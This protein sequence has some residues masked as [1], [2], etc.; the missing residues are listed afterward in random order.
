[1]LKRLCDIVA[2]TVGLCLLVPVFI[3]IAGVVKCSDGGPVFFRQRRI[4][5]N[6]QPFAIWKFR[7]M[8]VQAERQGGQITV[9]VD[10]RVTPVGHWLRKSKL[11]EFPQLLNVLRGE[12][13]LVG[14][15]PEVPKYVALYSQDQRR[16]LELKPGITDPSS[17]KYRDE[18]S[19]LAACGDPERA[20]VEV[21]MPDKIRLNLEY[22]ES[23]NLFSDAWMIAR[24][25][26]RIVLP[27]SQEP[28]PTHEVAPQQK[29]A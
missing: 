21:I 19:I 15:R 16:V 5:R 18:S 26:L 13:S 3:V 10:A 17:I 6:A 7:T 14:P 1:M 9:G 22:A 11:D 8:V 20:Y 4:G 12:M 29:A 27:S 25:L 2:A 28:L 24:T 23:A